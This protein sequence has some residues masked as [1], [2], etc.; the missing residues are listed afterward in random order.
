MAFPD[1]GLDYVVKPDIGVVNYAV[2]RIEITIVA[3]NDQP[4]LKDFIAEYCKEGWSGIMCQMNI[5]Y[6]NQQRF[7]LNHLYFT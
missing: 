1:S 7:P 4:I 6:F 2:G 5:N 3:Q